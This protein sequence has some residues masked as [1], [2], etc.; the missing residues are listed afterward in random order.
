MLL[1]KG[2]PNG[3]VTS[4]R[5]CRIICHHIRYSVPE[6]ERA[7]GWYLLSVTTKCATGGVSGWASGTVDGLDIAKTCLVPGWFVE[8]TQRLFMLIFSQNFLNGH[9]IRLLVLIF[10]QIFLEQTQNQ[11]ICAYFLTVFL[12][13]N[14]IRLLVLIFSLKFWNR[15]K[16]GFFYLFP[17]WMFGTDTKSD[18]LY[19]FSLWIFETDTKSDYLS[20][21]ASLP[22]FCY[23]PL[24]KA[25]PFF[26][27]L[28]VAHIYNRTTYSYCA[29]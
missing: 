12:N 14:K 20:S 28:N 19:L 21:K 17:R 23:E 11:I 1:C 15:H 26:L 10:S 24:S 6:A 16:T 25:K 29:Y 9:K 4:A 27:V 13:M 2:N 8:Q 3:T 5:T 22:L 7:D 18:Y